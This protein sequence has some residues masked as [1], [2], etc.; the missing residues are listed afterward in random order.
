MLKEKPCAA[1]AAIGMRTM[2]ERYPTMSDAPP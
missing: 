1:T 2:I